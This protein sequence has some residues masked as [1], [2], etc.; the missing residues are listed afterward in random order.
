MVLRDGLILTAAGLLI[1]LPVAATL[2]HWSASLLYG[3]HV[4]DPITFIAVPVLMMVAAALACVFPAWKA[5]RVDPVSSL[6][7]Q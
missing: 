3:I 1:G 4:L 7:H 5:S 2:A 6:R